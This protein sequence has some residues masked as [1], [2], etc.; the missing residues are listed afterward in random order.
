[1]QVVRSFSMASLLKIEVR[2]SGER[3]SNAW[4]TCPKDWDNFPKGKLIPDTFV[5]TH[6]FTKKAFGRFGM[7]PR[8]ISLLVG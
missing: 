7:G 4:A 5:D 3:V 8:S 6:V 1:M 2:D